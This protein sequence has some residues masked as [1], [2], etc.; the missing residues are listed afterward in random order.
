MPELH[1]VPPEDWDFKVKSWGKIPISYLLG[2]AVLYFS[3][4]LHTEY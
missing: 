4:S 2:S 3:E 1:S